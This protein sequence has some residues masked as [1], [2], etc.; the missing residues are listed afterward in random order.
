MKERGGWLALYKCR[1]SQ[2]W[3]NRKLMLQLAK[4]LMLSFTQ[5]DTKEK[6]KLWNFM[7]RPK[8][9]YYVHVPCL[10]GCDCPRLPF[11]L[12]L[13]K[14]GTCHSALASLQSQVRPDCYDSNLHN[15]LK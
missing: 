2:V 6:P 14:A 11:M 7:A 1:Y 3:S 10:S 12:A 13:S 8:T 9:L 4:K 15:K 5:K